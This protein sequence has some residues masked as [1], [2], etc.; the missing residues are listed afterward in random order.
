MINSKENALKILGLSDGASPE[1]WKSSYR[2]ICKRYHPDNLQSLDISPEDSAL[3][4]KY[5]M[6]AVEAYDYLESG[7][8]RN[9]VISGVTPARKPKVMG[10][11]ITFRGSEQAS[12]DK[13]VKEKLEKESLEK[14]KKRFE[15]L[16]TKGQEI[17]TKK[18]AD[19]L[20]DQI[21]WIRVAEIIRKTIEED[22]K[23][24]M[25]NGKE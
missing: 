21:R 10:A 24:V 11:P 8:G 1:E 16:K 7:K 4:E 2:A 12:R 6:L 14:K 9:D 13:K 5:Y 17:T 19:D 25:K 20:L 15:E 23:A 22:K 3:Y 18:K